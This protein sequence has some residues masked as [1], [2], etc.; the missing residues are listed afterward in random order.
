MSFDNGWDIYLSNYYP[1]PQILTSKTSRLNPYGILVLSADN[2]RTVTILESMNL[3]ITESDDRIFLLVKMPIEFN[4]DGKPG[5][6]QPLLSM[7]NIHLELDIEVDNTYEKVWKFP[8]YLGMNVGR[9]NV[10][11]KITWSDD[12]NQEIELSGI[13]ITWSMRA[14]L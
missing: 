13:A 6:V 8:T 4:L 2:G 5:A 12:G 7:Y 3:Q 1:T 9:S 10:K 14:L 11:G